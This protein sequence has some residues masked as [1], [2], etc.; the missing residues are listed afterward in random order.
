MF[1]YY[2]SA[3]NFPAPRTPVARKTR[4]QGKVKTPV[5]TVTPPVKKQK[6]ASSAIQPQST[7]AADLKKKEQGWC[8]NI[9]HNI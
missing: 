5:V 4:S 9:L 2:T 1:R 8:K 3:I 6:K 7:Y